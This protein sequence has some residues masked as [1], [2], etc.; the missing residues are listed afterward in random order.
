V[1][2]RRFE[3]VV[4][5]YV[6]MPEHVHLLSGD[7]HLGSHTPRPTSRR[8]CRVPLCTKLPSASAQSSY[9]FAYRQQVP[10]TTCQECARSVPL[11]TPLPPSP[12]PLFFPGPEILQIIINHNGIN[13]FRRP[14]FPA[15]SKRRILFSVG[16]DLQRG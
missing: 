10:G 13:A 8:S 15:Y 3:F 16:D 6:L 12:P 9:E 5:G 7:R 4:A 11:C 14:C 1:V 2:R